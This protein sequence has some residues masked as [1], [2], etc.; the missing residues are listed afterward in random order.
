MVIIEVDGCFGRRCRI[1]GYTDWATPCNDQERRRAKHV[2][3]EQK[4]RK[5][6]VGLSTV[7]SV[8]L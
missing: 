4:K 2:I 6:D 3:Y 5:I 8:V 1:C 7:K